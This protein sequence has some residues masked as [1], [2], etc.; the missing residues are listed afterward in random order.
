VYHSLTLIIVIYIINLDLFLRFQ[1]TTIN[2]YREKE[3][4]GNFQKG[5][6]MRSNR[7]RWHLELQVMLTCMFQ[8]LLGYL[9]NGQSGLTTLEPLLE[10][11]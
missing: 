6:I 2:K 1:E 4:L 11:S 10:Y 8:M 5:G 7:G 9:K 3:Y